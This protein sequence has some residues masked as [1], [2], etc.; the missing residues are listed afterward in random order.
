MLKPQ[1]FNP[2]FAVFTRKYFF[3]RRLIISFYTYRTIAADKEFATADLTDAL[4]RAR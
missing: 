3:Q 4:N 1:S 2:N